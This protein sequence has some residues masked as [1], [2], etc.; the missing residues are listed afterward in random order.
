VDLRQRQ[1]RRGLFIWVESKPQF[2]DAFLMPARFNELSGQSNG[3]SIP[4]KTYEPSSLKR[5]DVKMKNFCGHE[6]QIL[7]GDR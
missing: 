4:A 7:Q 1:R 5:F 2:G 3:V 6:G